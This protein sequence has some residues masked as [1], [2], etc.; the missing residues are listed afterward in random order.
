MVKG[1]SW[2]QNNLFQVERPSIH[3]KY[4][5]IPNS[6]L[7][8]HTFVSVVWTELGKQR[9]KLNI[10]FRIW[11]ATSRLVQ[12]KTLAYSSFQMLKQMSHSHTNSTTS[13]EE[14]K[15]NSCSQFCPICPRVWVQDGGCH[16]NSY[17]PH[18]SLVKVTWQ[19]ICGGCGFPGN[20]WVIL[21]PFFTNYSSKSW[22]SSP[23]SFFANTNSW[24]FHQK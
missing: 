4:C 8:W 14:G 12:K 15:E 5:T 7:F 2:Y 24:F 3:L 6:H 10:Q 9:K 22:A 23:S 1:M 19:P 17:R 16:V 21:P 20:Q 11:R 18:S 13:R